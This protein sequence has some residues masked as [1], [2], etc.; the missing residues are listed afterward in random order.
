MTTALEPS[1]GIPF[2]PDR[3]GEIGCRPISAM[4]PQA[5]FGEQS[6]KWNMQIPISLPD[7]DVF[8]GR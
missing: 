5:L 2:P 7:Q 3:V 4:T 8:N 6:Q 1:S